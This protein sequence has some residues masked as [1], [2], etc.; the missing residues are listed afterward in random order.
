MT[1][2]TVGYGDLAPTTDNSKLFT[3]IFTFLSVGIFVSLN[4]KIVLM[5]LNQKKEKLLKQKVKKGKSEV[6]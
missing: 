5:M 2:S 4:A 1:M 3:I 6:E